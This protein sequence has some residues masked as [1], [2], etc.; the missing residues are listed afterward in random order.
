MTNILCDLCWLAIVYLHKFMHGCI[1]DPVTKH[2]WLNMDD[3]NIGYFPAVLFS[4][5]ATAN[6]VG[7]GGM[8]T[9][10]IGSSSPQMGSGLFPDDNF[11]HACYFREVT[12]RNASILDNAPEKYMINTF[13]DR[14]SCFRVE[15]YG[16]QGR[17]VGHSLQFGGPGGDCDD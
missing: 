3:K 8:T 17:Q 9:T 16:D 14:P 13:A 5:L 10:P 2:W 15:Y 4:N 6:Q 12:Y 11:I 7:W 1:Q